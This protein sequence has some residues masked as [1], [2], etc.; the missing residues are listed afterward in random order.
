MSQYYFLMFVVNS[1]YGNWIV[2]VM[3]INI[4]TQKHEFKNT[5]FILTPPPEISRNPWV[6]GN[7]G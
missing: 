5:M 3:I 7:P 1:K 6:P 4:N 2:L